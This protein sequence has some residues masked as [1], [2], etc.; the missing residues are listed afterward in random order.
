MD[1]V[2]KNIQKEIKLIEHQIAENQKLLDTD[3]NPDLQIM[4][5]D[6]IKALEKHKLDLEMSLQALES[7]VFEQEGS[8][9][10]TEINPN[11]AILEI[12]AGTGGDEAGL[13]ALDLYRMYLRYAEK[14]GW[15]TEEL[16]FSEN[17]MGGIKTATASLKGKDAY[18]VLKHESGVHRVQR[19]PVTEAG[20]RIHT[21]TATVAVLPEVKK[22]NV[23]IRPE[24][25]K[26]DFFRSGGH[27]G[28]N[29]NKVSTAVRL[30]HIPTG[31]VVE[32][33]E[34]RHQAKNRE[35]AMEIL[36]S[37]L[38]NMMKEQQVQNISDLRSEQVGSGE[39]SEKIR[40]YNYPQDRITDHRL[41]ENFHNIPAIMNGEIEKLLEEMRKIELTL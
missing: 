40:T 21:S 24:D 1:Q 9:S 19:V 36:K 11:S 39:R 14:T 10:D 35:K 12:R 17:P 30:T 31:V 38:Y 15:K 27:G 25:I 4:V 18:N 32:C 7:D 2:K 13:F 26:I 5:T 23:D 33:Q 6:E 41:N 37:R 8:V 16:F 3:P 34:E 29:V 20:G 28:Q 22:I